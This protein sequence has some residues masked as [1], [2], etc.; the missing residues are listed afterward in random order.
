MSRRGVEKVYDNSVFGRG[1]WNSSD[2]LMDE[3]SCTGEEKEFL[4]CSY[5]I[6]HDCSVQELVS[7]VCRENT[8]IV[9]QTQHRFY[10]NG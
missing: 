7:V 1:P 10:K 8:G 5:T 4:S 6:N 9:K 3:V 2:I